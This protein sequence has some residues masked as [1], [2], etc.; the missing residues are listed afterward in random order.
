MTRGGSSSWAGLLF[1]RRLIS[2]NDREATRP[3]AG[4]TGGPKDLAACCQ[5]VSAQNGQKWRARG[6]AADRSPISRLTLGGRHTRFR[7]AS[8]SALFDSDL[9]QPFFFE[10]SRGKRTFLFL[11]PMGP[12]VLPRNPANALSASVAEVT[13]RANFWKK[14]PENRT[15]TVRN[16]KDLLIIGR[17]SPIW[18]SGN[19]W[20]KIPEKNPGPPKSRAERVV[21]RFRLWDRRVLHGGSR[22]SVPR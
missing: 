7:S 15:G 16:I 20:K 19:F 11:V 17:G 2:D 5:V 13:C 6:V 1:G 12:A 22:S 8:A 10:L 4:G 21:P 9:H 3:S 14:I 18:P